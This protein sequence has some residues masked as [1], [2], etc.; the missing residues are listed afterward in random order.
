M[1]FRLIGLVVSFGIVGYLLYSV[2][3]SDSKLD[4][5]INA[6]PAVMEQKKAL[7]GAGVNAGD[8]KE[9]KKYL[10]DQAKQLEEYQSQADN[11][12][13]DP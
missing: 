13:K 2:L 4:Q 6:N 1:I 8:K 10:N 7:E 3:S 5:K 11:L 9:L 12:P